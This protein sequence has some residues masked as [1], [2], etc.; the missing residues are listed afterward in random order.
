MERALEVDFNEI[1]MRRFAPMDP[2][3]GTAERNGRFHE[4]DL[5]DGKE[6]TGPAT[7]ELEQVFV[8]R[9]ATLGR[10]VAGNRDLASPEVAPADRTWV[11]HREGVADPV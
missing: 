7:P 5:V 8:N 1:E 3:D 10:P 9:D 6:V 4:I 2:V 11:S